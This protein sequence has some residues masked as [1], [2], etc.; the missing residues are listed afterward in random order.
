MFGRY[1][2]GWKILPHFI[3]NGFR[4]S[5]YPLPSRSNDMCEKLFFT[6]TEKLK[7]LTISWYLALKIS[8]NINDSSYL[9]F[10]Y[11]CLCLSWCFC[12]INVLNVWRSII[13]AFF[14]TGLS[15]CCRIILTSSCCCSPW[16]W[17]L[18]TIKSKRMVQLKIT[19]VHRNNLCSTVLKT[20][21]LNIACACPDILTLH[22]PVFLLSE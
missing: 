12:D 5:A 11:V 19:N 10:C 2:V 14:S 21:R 18:R 9:W 7:C 17:L 15:C 20:I 3:F 1:F 6:V 13:I 16:E 8:C 22:D 4:A